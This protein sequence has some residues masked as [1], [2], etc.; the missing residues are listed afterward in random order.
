LAEA[1][2][3]TS[4]NFARSHLVGLFE[5]LRDLQGET[6]LIH[7]AVDGQAIA[8]IVANWTGVPAGRMRSD[9]IH[10]VLGLRASLEKRVI[11][12]PH[13]IDA[14]A[15]AVQTA[16]AKLSDPRKPLAV[17]LMA[18]T[19]GVGKTETALALAEAL[20][21]GEQNLTT[22]NMSEFKEEHKVSLLMG[23]PPGYVGYGEGGLLTEAV[24]RRPYSVILLDEMEKAHPGVQ[25]V[26]YQVFDKGTMTD[27]EGREIDFRNTVIIMTSNA[28]TDV[29]TKLFA[30]PE[31][32]PDADELGEAL[33]PALL[34]H[35]KPAFL[36]RVTLVPYLPLPTDIIR[37]IVRMQ[38]ARVARR[39]D[40]TYKARF[41]FGESVVDS[42]A[43]RCTESGA[44]ARNV[45]SIL[46][47]T[48]LPEVSARVLARLGDALPITEVTVV[49]DVEGR[50]D[51]TIT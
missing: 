44:G 20:Y 25:D 26:F 30:D 50:F 49:T 41:A 1:E 5:T 16:A 38:L 27:G 11:G 3:E 10:N 12:Q 31:T 29:I 43:E 39:L 14:V 15:R 13:A 7:P 45:E 40:E 35:F 36:G 18:G 48:L 34:R 9:A 28:G 19:S 24:R 23:S 47:R 33:R 8:E 4:R 42:I 32:A 51:Y 37:R 46:S 2:G 6:P 17:F 21:G 22:I